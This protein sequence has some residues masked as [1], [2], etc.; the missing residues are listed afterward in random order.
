M[1]GDHPTM[2]DMAYNQARTNAS[3]LGQLEEQNQRLESEIYLLKQRA[4][5]FTEWSND[6]AERLNEAL[7]ALAR[8]TNYEPMSD[9][10]GEETDD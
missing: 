4:D 2:G 3:R 7:I 5:L 1:N 8:H 6:L 10:T 9:F